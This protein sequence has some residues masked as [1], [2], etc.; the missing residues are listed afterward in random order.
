MN[1]AGVPNGSMSTASKDC[2]ESRELASRQVTVTG[3]PER[4]TFSG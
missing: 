4:A 3:S 2:S 1:G